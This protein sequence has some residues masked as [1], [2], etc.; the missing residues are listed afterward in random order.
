[1]DLQKTLRRRSPG[2]ILNLLS[3]SAALVAGVSVGNGRSEMKRPFSKA[4]AAA[5]AVGAVILAGGV[6]V[7]ADPFGGK[8]D[9]DAGVKDAAS[10][11]GVTP[12]KLTDALQG[13]IGDRIDAA[14]AA[15]R[16]TKEQGDRLEQE[17]A[18]GELP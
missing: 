11:L 9:R 3:R 6:A 18:N 4:T 12:Q 17:V 10:R 1:M 5:F 8:A 16:L 14:V 15:G 7:A 2:G 13:A